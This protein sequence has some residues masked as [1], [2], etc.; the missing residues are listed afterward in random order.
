M[1]RGLTRT[2]QMKLRTVLESVATDISTVLNL[3][4]EL[5]ATASEMPTQGTPL[6]VAIVSRKPARSSAEINRC[7]SPECDTSRAAAFNKETEPNE[8]RNADSKPRDEL[9]NVMSAFEKLV[10][11]LR[12]HGDNV[13]LARP[14]QSA[15]TLPAHNGTS[16]DSLAIDTRYDGKGIIVHCHAN[17]DTPS[18]MAALGL[19]MSDL[20]D[21]PQLK[22]AWQP[23]AKYLYPGGRRST[24]G[25]ARTARRPSTSRA[26]RQTAVSSTPTASATTMVIYVVEG[27]KDVLAIEAIG[28]PRSAQRW[29]Q[30]RRT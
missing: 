20:F 4:V 9:L 22:N 12:A 14:G 18:V 8:L 3:P 1:S 10:D 28:R 5:R 24:A 2:E 15:S 25:L 17:C 29:E 27:E 6:Y 7:P 30:V 11:A 19:T 16:D 21:D 26:R 13:N 23:F